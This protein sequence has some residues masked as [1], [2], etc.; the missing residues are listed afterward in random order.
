MTGHDDPPDAG[1]VPF[2]RRAAPPVPPDH[3]AM[4]LQTTIPVLFLVLVRSGVISVEELAILL[5]E[6]EDGMLASVG[7]LGGQRDYPRLAGFGASVRE[8][9]GGWRS[10]L[11]RMT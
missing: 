10:H 4:V 8:I 6:L 2:P 1:P 3:R 5:D 9:I 11:A 7:D